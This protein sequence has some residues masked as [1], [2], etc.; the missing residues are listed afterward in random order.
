MKHLILLAA[1]VFPVALAHSELESATPAEG[2][3][4]AAPREVKLRFSEEVE[5][6]FST[7]K[8]YPVGVTG[9]VQRV[10]AAAGML[11]AQH[12]NRRDDASQRADLGVSEK[13][14]TAREVTL[15]LKQNLTPGAY[16][17]MWK[18]LS[19]DTHTTEGFYVFNVR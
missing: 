9:S 8:V 18:V 5:L 16:V 15:P 6:K 14:R 12:L 11:K 1:L 3:R 10:N 19:V 4:V 13:A 7:F 2:S 17:V